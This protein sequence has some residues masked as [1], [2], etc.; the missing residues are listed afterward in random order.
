MHTIHKAPIVIND[1][2]KQTIYEMEN[3]LDNLLITGNAGTGKSTLLELFRKS[4]T[5]KLAV[6]AP[7]GV[8]A[9]HVR[10]QTVHSFFGI[11]PRLVRS[12]DIEIRR[13]KTKLYKSLEIIVIDEVSML[14][15]DILDHINYLLQTYRKSKDPFG[16]VKMIFVGDLYQLPP[17]VSA[18]EQ[19]YFFQNYETPYFFSAKCMLQLLAFQIIELKKIF[20]QKDPAFIQLLRQIRFNSMETEDFELVNSRYQTDAQTP[21]NA[22]TLTAT[23]AAS[24]AINKRQLELIQETSSIY[25]GKLSGEFAQQIVPVEQMLM[26]KTNAQV[27]LLRNDPEGQYA[28]GSIGQVTDCSPE[29][30]TVLI[31]NQ[32]GEEIQTK[33][34][35]N[36]WEII[37]YKFSEDTQGELHYEVAGTY[38]QLPL[39]L[40]WAITIHK[41]QGK[42]F[43]QIVIDLGRGA[44]EFGQTYVAL[45]RCTSLSGILLR[46]P[47][48]PQDIQSDE[49][50]IDFLRRFQ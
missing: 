3:G 45:S 7:T 15:A 10:G 31:K 20:R 44:F 47:L 24:D 38:T 41:S 39:K 34:S 19:N 37:R 12:Q 42:T 48:R 22:V 50:I 49:R 11:P 40:A 9:L 28:N 4:S 6:L 46:K 25:N 14:R 5:K 2:F 16:G 17:V 32:D 33:I 43:D 21:T 36:T 29:H 27:M 13:Y 23:N 18:N 1:Q 26:L 35:Q 8:A 30:V